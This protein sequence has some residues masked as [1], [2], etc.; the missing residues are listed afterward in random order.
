[1]G[2][3]EPPYVLSIALRQGRLASS[4]ACTTLCHKT[5]EEVVLSMLERCAADWSIVPLEWT[6]PDDPSS[7]LDMIVTACKPPVILKTAKRQRVASAFDALLEMRRGSARMH[8]EAQTRLPRSSSAAAEPLAAPLEP[9]LGSRDE[10][11]VHLG[12]MADLRDAALLEVD[13]AVDGSGFDLDVAS[14]ELL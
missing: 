7:L 14:D 9:D 13:A 12:D 10:E 5:S 2:A 4:Q 8:G 1:M 3:F 6:F 11:D